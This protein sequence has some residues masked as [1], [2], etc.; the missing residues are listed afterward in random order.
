MTP[1]MK[2]VMKQI[3]ENHT[4]AAIDDVYALAEVYVKGTDNLFDDTALEFLKSLKDSLIQKADEIDG[5]DN[6]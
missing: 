6:R 5:E 1:E 2:K 4:V 3:A